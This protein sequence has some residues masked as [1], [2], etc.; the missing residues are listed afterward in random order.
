[1]LAVPAPVQG[2]RGFTL[3]ELIIVMAIVA[4][5]ASLA[6]PLIKNWI[7]NSEIRTTA[8]GLQNALRST[9]AEAVRRSSQVIFVI[10]A[11]PGV[12]NGTPALN[13]NYWYIQAV[14]TIAGQPADAT[15]F[16]QRSPAGYASNGI[17]INTT[18]G[19]VCFNS[20]GRQVTNTA[21]GVWPNIPGACTA[22]DTTYTITGPTGTRTLRVV[23]SLG[24]KIRMC[25]PNKTLS[26]TNP[27]G[28]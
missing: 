9:S 22:Q 24:G 16:V 7:Q 3:V 14:P 26:T 8:D 20:I 13:G 12:L 18:Q 2:H 5:L 23:A 25:D 17:N 4:L 27:D 11:S 19:V 10:S 15:D 6:T 1:M 21:T 28:C